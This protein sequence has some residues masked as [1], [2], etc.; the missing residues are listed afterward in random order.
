ML[1]SSRTQ[2]EF[3][4]NKSTA[5][6]AMFD[7]IKYQCWKQ[8]DRRSITMNF[9]REILKNSQCKGDASRS[10]RRS[11]WT[12]GGTEAPKDVPNDRGRLSGYTIRQYWR[13]WPN[14]EVI[15]T[16]GQYRQIGMLASTS[17]SSHINSKKSYMQ[18]APIISNARTT[19][20]NC[21]ENFLPVI[22][23]LRFHTW[24]WTKCTPTTLSWSET[25]TG[26]RSSRRLCPTRRKP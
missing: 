12:K 16:F 21:F 22:H 23:L 1:F 11:S 3:I 17:C 6:R 14:A 24:S 9:I 26:T 13:S 5:T 18:G 4:V 2:V 20:W 7:M 15:W 10:Q 25:N 8:R 19:S